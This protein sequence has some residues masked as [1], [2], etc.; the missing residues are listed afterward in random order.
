MREKW[1]LNQIWWSTFLSRIKAHLLTLD[2]GEG[3]FSS[4][5]KANQEVGATKAKKSQNPCWL[6]EKEK[7][8]KTTLGWGFQGLWSACV[9]F[10]HW[11]VLKQGDI[12]E[13]LI[14]NL[15]ILSSLGSKRFWSKCSHHPPSGWGGSQFLQN[16]SKRS[17]RCYIYPLRSN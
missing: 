3:K 8:L 6:Q 14:I 9:L 15:L 12:I 1:L 7:F 10:S 17:V 16:N 11:L 5:C 13:I 4:Y 2:C